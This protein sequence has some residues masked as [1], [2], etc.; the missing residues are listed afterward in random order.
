MLHH[1]IFEQKTKRTVVSME[2]VENVFAEDPSPSLR[3][4]APNVGVSE[5]TLWEILRWD[6]KAKFYR[7]TLVQKLSDDH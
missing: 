4:V 3:K 1:S 7:V 6:M 5:C 2:Q